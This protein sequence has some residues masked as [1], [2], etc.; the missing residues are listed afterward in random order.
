MWIQ[1]NTGTPRVHWPG[2]GIAC[3]SYVPLKWQ[4]TWSP[5]ARRVC[6][7]EVQ[8]W[9]ALPAFITTTLTTPTAE[10][11]LS[12]DPSTQSCAL[13]CY[14]DFLISLVHLTLCLPLVRLLLWQ[15]SQLP[16]LTSGYPA[17]ALRAG[18]CPFLLDLN[19]RYLW[20]WLC[21]LTHTALFL[22]LKFTPIMFL[23]LLAAS[24]STWL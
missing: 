4:P 13:Y 23:Q 11:S 2:D 1:S 14:V 18:S 17:Y 8:Q 20:P 9:H 24:S 16:L 15:S 6:S 10:Q 5:A 19:Y 12:H 7:R 3:L 22:S 21:S